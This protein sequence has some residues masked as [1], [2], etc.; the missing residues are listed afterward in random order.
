M[1]PTSAPSIGDTYQRFFSTDTKE[2]E[3]LRS[4]TPTHTVLPFHTTE[5]SGEER[6]ICWLCYRAGEGHLVGSYRGRNR[7]V[8]RATSKQKVKGVVRPSKRVKDKLHCLREHR[9]CHLK[10]GVQFPVL[11][12][13]TADFELAVKG[14]HDLVAALTEKVALAMQKFEQ[15]SNAKAREAA[16]PEGAIE[17]E[18]DKRIADLERQLVEAKKLSGHGSNVVVEE[19]SIANEEASVANGSPLMAVSVRHSYSSDFS[20]LL[21]H[22]LIQSS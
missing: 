4:A 5:V 9:K 18:K 19:A 20:K 13:M 14:G 11:L 2:A 8:K 16:E 7:T 22:K 10:A 17:D 1:Q 12:D 21:Q 3:A 15:V 6:K